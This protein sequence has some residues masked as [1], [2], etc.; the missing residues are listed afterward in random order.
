[1]TPIIVTIVA[2][3]YAAVWL[4]PHFM[5]I[6]ITVLLSCGEFVML[7]TLMGFLFACQC[8][9]FKHRERFT[10]WLHKIFLRSFNGVSIIRLD[11]GRY[12]DG[13]VMYCF[14][15]H[16]MV[17]NGFGLGILSV[18]RTSGKPI[19]IAVARSLSW[20]NPVF[21]WLVN[22]HGIHMCTVGRKDLEREMSLGR[23]IGLC[24]GGFEEALLMRRLAD[25]VFLRRRTGFLH[26]ACDY[27]YTLIQVF[28]FGESL[29]YENVL[30]LSLSLRRCA[31]RCGLPL[32]W[33]RGNSWMSFNPKKLPAGLRI[34]FSE[35][36]EMP[37]ADYDTLHAIY[38]QRLS[39]LHSR[40]NLYNETTLVVI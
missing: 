27:S 30:P 5:V 36:I 29:L 33:P 40:F 26:L 11:S 37:Q 24:P 17:A 2:N 10:V 7:C 19:T 23:N 38:I 16:A 18:L 12:H 3:A 28:T 4:V 34:V 21:R 15:P 35:P 9:E 20:L 14:H 22:S 8:V 32:V 25:V 39:L 31:A 1:M 6:L 13:P